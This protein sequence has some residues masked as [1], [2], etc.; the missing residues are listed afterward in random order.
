MRVGAPAPMQSHAGTPAWGGNWGGRKKER[1][2]AEEG[3]IPS[4][5]Y[6]VEGGRYEFSGRP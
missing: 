1:W 2:R 5:G 6:G 4:A 3:S